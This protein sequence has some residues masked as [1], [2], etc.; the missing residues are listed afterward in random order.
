MTQ[1]DSRGDMNVFLFFPLPP[2][3]FWGGEVEVGR[4]TQWPRLASNSQQF[5]C[6]SLQTSESPP[7]LKDGLSRG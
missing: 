7:L 3:F 6:L 4:L 2:L 1:Y 5:S